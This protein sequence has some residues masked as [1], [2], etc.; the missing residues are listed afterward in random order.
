LS[1]SS[2]WSV[3]GSVERK[4]LT[5][6]LALFYDEESRKLGTEEHAAAFDKA[7][8]IQI[9][10]NLFRGTELLR[11]PLANQRRAGLAHPGTAVRSPPRE[12]EDRCQ[13]ALVDQ[14]A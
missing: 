2:L 3:A 9:A 8:A 11:L 1:P 14:G 13:A 4:L 6:A 5:G 12:P 10:A 7:E